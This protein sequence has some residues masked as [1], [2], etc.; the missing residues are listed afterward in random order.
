MTLPTTAAGF[1]NLDVLVI[2]DDTRSADLV[3]ETLVSCG[4]SR[5]ARAQSAVD[6]RRLLDARTFDAILIECDLRGGDAFALTRTIRTTSGSP[7]A[8]APILMLSKTTS[9]ERVHR[10]RDVGA[11]FTLA[12]PLS[13]A[14]LQERLLWIARHVRTHI[15]TET[16]CGPDRRVRA[17]P[18]PEGIEERR[19]CQLQLTAT[20]ER[21]LSQ[22]EID[23]LFN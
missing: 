20:P 23:G 9:M 3:V 22:N 11:N 15:D 6:I 17:G 7:N 13:P 4:V 2:D 12:R 1:R 18:P 10:A 16:Y 14:V 5:T 21:E 19:Q 8:T